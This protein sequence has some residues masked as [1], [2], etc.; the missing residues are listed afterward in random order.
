MGKLLE[1]TQAGDREG[2][3]AY[4]E[5]KEP[6]DLALEAEEFDDE[7]LEMLL[8]LLDTSQRAEVLEYAEDQ[9]RYR[10]AKT[11]DPDELI[12]AFGYMQKDDIVD[13]LGDFPIGKRKQVVD[14]MQAND[15]K[16][17][18]QLLAYPEDTAGGL[19][20][21]AYIA[22]KKERSIG[23]CLDKIREIA[24]RTEIIETIYVI[25][26]D[27]TLVGTA[28]LRDLL[29]TPRD[30][31]LESI[32]DSHVISVTPEVDQ[33]EV[34]KLVSKYDLPAIPVVSARGRILG[35]VTVDDVI[36]V[37]VEEYDEDMLEMAGINKE[38]RLDTPFR[39][40][41][42]MRLPWLLINLATAFLASA[43][44]KSFESVIAQVVALSAIMT[45]VSGMGGN[46]GTQT[47]SLL[48]RELARGDISAA[49]ARRSFGKEILLGIANGAINGFVTGMIVYLVYGNFYLGLI[50]LLA[51]IGNLMVSGIF[52]FLVP[53]CL[54]RLHA[55]PAVSSSIFVT[56]ATDVLGFFIFLGLA[57]LFLP[58]LV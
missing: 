21:T 58:L 17:V 33:E 50:V 10:L 39:Q 22:L 4:F 44:V 19:M 18:R 54:Y 12:D 9:L 11:M 45:I 29:T 27:S 13:L 1:L 46:A 7:Q 15:R 5:E 35:I 30:Q 3:Q 34:A 48:V 14:R 51:M 56:T 31:T 52:G 43:V 28:D 36:D 8:A 20:S 24:P 40:S 16:I 26:T 57:K 32:M 38:E 23:Q 25:D 55:D 2:I 37:I 53:L 42:R 47:L 49:Q 6:A 41:L